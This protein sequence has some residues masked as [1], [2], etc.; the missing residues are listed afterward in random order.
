MYEIWSKQLKHIVVAYAKI[1]AEFQ[2]V[3]LR[4]IPKEENHVANELAKMAS[5]VIQWE[6]EDPIT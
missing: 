1:K 3:T 4:Q 2:E 5:N 6:T